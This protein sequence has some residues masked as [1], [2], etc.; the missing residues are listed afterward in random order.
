M[1]LKA[2]PAS[3]LE[4]LLASGASGVRGFHRAHSELLYLENVPLLGGYAHVQLTF[5]FPSV[6]AELQP[7]HTHHGRLRGM[8]L[9]KALTHV[10]ARS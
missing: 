1:Q 6:V 4:E 7:V 9:H 10:S 2:E 5:S 3:A 8:C